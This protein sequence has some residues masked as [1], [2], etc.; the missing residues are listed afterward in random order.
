MRADTDARV[1]ASSIGSTTIEPRGPRA[2]ARVV[3][4]QREG[5]RHA[6]DRSFRACEG[7]AH[8]RR[9]R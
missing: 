8:V 4:S 6:I 5:Q 9:P 1:W 2:R 7:S 3:W